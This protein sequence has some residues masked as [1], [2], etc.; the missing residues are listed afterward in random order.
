MPS[1]VGAVTTLGLVGLSTAAPVFDADYA[2]PPT[3][4]RP[5]TATW[6][7]LGLSGTPSAR[8]VSFSKEEVSVAEISATDTVFI[9]ATEEPIDENEI[10]TTDTARLSITDTAALF[11]NVAVTDNARLSASET[12]GLAIVGVN[13][14]SGSDTASLSVSESLIIAVSL[15]VTDTASLSLTETPTVSETLEVLSVTDT[16]SISVD[17]ELLREVFTGVQEINVLDTALLAATESTSV[18]DVRR[19]KRIAISITAPRIK[20]DIT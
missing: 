11:N 2:T 12:V 16:A 10:L 13:A 4:E 7:G 5:Y 15:A 3:F 8:A 6:T 18:L 20:I 19:I 17:E 9:T 14:K 1:L